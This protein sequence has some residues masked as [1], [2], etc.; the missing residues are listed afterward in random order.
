MQVFDSLLSSKS[1]AHIYKFFLYY[2]PYMANCFFLVQEISS[3]YL[4]V[5]SKK[6]Y[7]LELRILR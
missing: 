3:I 6:E 1:T 7:A 5:V 2:N 4:N